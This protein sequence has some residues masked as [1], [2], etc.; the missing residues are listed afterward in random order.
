VQ[1]SLFLWREWLTVLQMKARCR[2]RSACVGVQYHKV[3][4]RNLLS[5]KADTPTAAHGADYL[6]NSP[7]HVRAVILHYDAISYGQGRPIDVFPFDVHNYV[8]QR[9]G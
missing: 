1:R 8:H 9:T 7:R 2:K 3:C 5:H 4:E 6:H